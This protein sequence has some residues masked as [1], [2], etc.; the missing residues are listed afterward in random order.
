MFF[1]NLISVMNTYELYRIM[2]Y[3]FKLID[4]NKILHKKKKTKMIDNFKCL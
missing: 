1:K 4:Q 3:N 2:Y